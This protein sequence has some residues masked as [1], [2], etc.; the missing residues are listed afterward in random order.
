M[1]IGV[2]PS[3]LSLACLIA[4]K[5][6]IS[7]QELA[8]IEANERITWHSGQ[9]LPN[10]T[11]LSD[12][13]WDLVSPVEP[14]S[15]FSFLNYMKDKGKLQE[16]LISGIKRPRRSEF[17]D[18]LNWSA[19]QIPFIEFGRKII[20]IDFNIEKSLF[21]IS[22]DIDGEEVLEF[23]Q[24]IVLGVGKKYIPIFNYPKSSKVILASD[25]MH[26]IIS[27]L[28][29][30]DVV[31]IGSGQSSAEIISYLIN[32]TCVNKIT[33]ITKAASINDIDNSPFR[34]VAFTDIGSQKHFAECDNLKNTL[35]NK[36]KPLVNGVDP[37]FSEELFE[38][39]FYWS[40]R[41]DKLFE[42]I[43]NSTVNSIGEVD[44]LLNINFKKEGKEKACL[45]SSLAIICTGFSSGVHSDILSDNLT[46]ILKQ[47]DITENYEFKVSTNS[48]MWLQSNNIISH[49]VTDSNFITSPSRNKRIIESLGSNKS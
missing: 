24:N 14:T 48:S 22:S 47:N 6:I 20:N 1:G 4:E 12:Y 23:A 8:F 16:F 43:T 7:N 32:N 42:V 29:L 10:A 25:F 18:Y 41:E 3:N 11:M 2:G 39:V 37:S 38:D 9:I 17:E 13:V 27:P 31:V 34:G 36:E 15:R 26:K 19:R 33:W 35:R 45:Y 44:G 5:G 46:S 40:N 21:E 30:D 49:G 28:N